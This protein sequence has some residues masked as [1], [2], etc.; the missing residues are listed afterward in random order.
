MPMEIKFLVWSVGLTLIQVAIAATGT[1]L[2][3]GLVAGVGNRDNMPA[4]DGWVGRAHRAHKNMLESL[5]LFAAL[6]LVAQ[7]LGKFSPITLLGAQLFFW[8]R[9][10]YA[11]IYLAGI[12]WLRTLAWTVAIAGIVMIFLQVMQ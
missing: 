7:A 8:G 5:V 6:V 9:V 4:F 3:A 2:T 10:A 12:P 1:V 11:V